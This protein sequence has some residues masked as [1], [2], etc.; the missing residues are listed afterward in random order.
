MKK[1][2][3]AIHTI[4]KKI[5]FIRGHKVMLDRDLATLYG[6]KTFNLNKAVHRNRIRFPEDFMFRLNKDE[7]ESLRFQSGILER[8]R[9]SK[10][11]PSV[12]TQEG[13]AML[14]SVLRSERAIRVNIQIMRTFVRVRE[15][16]SERKDLAK[17]L[18]NLEKRLGQHSARFQ[19]VHNQI[20]ELFE[21]VWTLMTVAEKP[22][23]RI[24]FRN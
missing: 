12:F 7:Y 1:R 22:S 6:V 3:V 20:K 9:H 17:K 24:G 4:E 14:S 15:I 16:L 23:R 13:I 2:A 11:L 5:F 18:F 21:I 10:Y 19:K 8:G